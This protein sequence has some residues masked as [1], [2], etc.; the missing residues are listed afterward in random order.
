DGVEFASNLNGLRYFDPVQVFDTQRALQQ[1]SGFGYSTLQVETSSFSTFKEHLLP[2][3]NG[4]L[5]AVVSKT[6]DGSARVLA[7]NDVADVDMNGERCT[8]LN[9]EDFEV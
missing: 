1:C 3:G 4:S 2:T 8:P 5:K 9:I 7:L 6:F